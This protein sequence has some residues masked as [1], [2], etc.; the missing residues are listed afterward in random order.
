MKKMKIVILNKYLYI[1]KLTL[2]FS[3]AMVNFYLSRVSD[4]RE[5]LP[6]PL[7]SC[8]KYFTYFMV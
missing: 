7:N 4:V 6:F 3:L 2:L 1:K 8:K 5:T